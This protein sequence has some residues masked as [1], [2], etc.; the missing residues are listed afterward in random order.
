MGNRVL[1][2]HVKV[3][4]NTIKDP[5]CS[6][7]VDAVTFAKLWESYPSD[8]HPYTDPKTG[9]PPPGFKNQC[10]IKVSVAIH[11]AGIEMKSFRGDAKQVHG[12]PV[13]YVAS[14]LAEWLKLQPF[15]GLPMKPENVTGKDWQDKI[16]DRT[17]I[18]YF[19]NYWMREGETKKPTGD[20]I[21]LWNKST[22]TTNP[23]NLVRRFGIRS[24]HWLPGP[25]AEYN[26]SDLGNS[27]EILFWEVK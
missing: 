5:V 18:I 12:L 25:F 14:Q 10:A 17:G 6:V 16:K 21:D 4:T 3:R 26:F 13:A 7:K 27:T 1:T 8:H 20:H 11:G 15:C 23:A 9:K 19:A 24:I 2:Q 22:L